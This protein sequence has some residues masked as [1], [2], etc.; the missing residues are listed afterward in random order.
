MKAEFVPLKKKPNYILGCSLI[1]HVTLPGIFMC[2][3]RV[4][5]RGGEREPETLRVCCCGRVWKQAAWVLNLTECEV[6]VGLEEGGLAS[7]G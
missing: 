2:S 1:V 5:W 6:V 3:E 7:W 4:S